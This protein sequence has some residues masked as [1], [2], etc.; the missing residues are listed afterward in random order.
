MIALVALAGM[1]TM[2]SPVTESRMWPWAFPWL[3]LA[4]GLARFAWR[5]AQLRPSRAFAA[6]VSALLAAWTAV[7][8]AG[9]D[10]SRRWELDAQFAAELDRL[11]PPGLPVVLESG[12]HESVVYYGNRRIVLSTARDWLAAH[13]NDPTTYFV[14]EGSCEGVDGEIVTA[15]RGRSEKEPM[16]LLRPRSQPPARSPDSGSASTAPAP[17][18][19]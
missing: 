16:I 13:P 14:C 11:V 4:A 7:S 17:S 12:T 19:Q 2:R 6:Y 3:L 5:S 9:L 1:A 10:T 18:P 15:E 8:F